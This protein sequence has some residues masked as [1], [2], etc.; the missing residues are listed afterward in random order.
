[1]G[2]AAQWEAVD[3]SVA[4]SKAGKISKRSAVS[5]RE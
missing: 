1:V 3:A 5:G 4:S 2:F